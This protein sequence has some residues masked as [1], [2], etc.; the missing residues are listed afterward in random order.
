MAPL[1]HNPGKPVRI[2]VFAEPALV[3]RSRSLP[4]CAPLQ[5]ASSYSSR[6][7][8]LCS[9]ALSNSL[10]FAA[11]AYRAS[12]AGQHDVAIAAGAEPQFVGA[13]PLMAA[14]VDG[15]LPLDFTLAIA[16]PAIMPTLGAK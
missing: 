15:E 7:I 16:T 4:I 3:P 1:P 14:L 12:G 11:D 13:E 5:H 10:S 9:R 8:P 6:C 2:A